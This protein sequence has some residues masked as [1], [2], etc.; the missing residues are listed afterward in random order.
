MSSS[1]ARSYPNNTDIIAV[2]ILVLAILS[3]PGETRIMTRQ[4]KRIYTLKSSMNATS[5]F[6]SGSS[7][8]RMF[9]HPRT[10][11]SAGVEGK[12]P[13]LWDGKGSIRASVS[14]LVAEP[15]VIDLRLRDDLGATMNATSSDHGGHKYS[16]SDSEDQKEYRRWKAWV[17]AKMLRWTRCPRKLVV[18]RVFPLCRPAR[19]LVCGTLRAIEVPDC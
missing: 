5:T 14:T 11:I 12:R 9:V 19:H 1:K 4:P 3:R 10:N 17:Q 15:G 18:V 16:S 2:L 6:T 7:H 8:G 13:P